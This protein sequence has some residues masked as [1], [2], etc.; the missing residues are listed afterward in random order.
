VCEVNCRRGRKVPR[1]AGPAA[2]RTA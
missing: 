2:E 1:T